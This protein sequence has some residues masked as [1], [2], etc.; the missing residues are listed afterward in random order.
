MQMLIP[1]AVDEEA[2]GWIGS[3]EKVGY[4]VLRSAGDATTLIQWVRTLSVI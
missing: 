4:P 1:K 3:L 2:A